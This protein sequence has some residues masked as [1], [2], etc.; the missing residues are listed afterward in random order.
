MSISTVTE[1]GSFFSNV[2]TYPQRKMR[3]ACSSLMR[4]MVFQMGAY[5]ESTLNQF[6]LKKN[7]AGRTIDGD[8]VAS[9]IDIL[10]AIGGRPK[11]MEL[12]DGRSKFDY[13]FFSQHRFKQAVEANGG[14]F[15]TFTRGHSNV[16]IMSTSKWLSE[17]MEEAEITI[18]C[19]NLENDNQ[20]R[21]PVFQETI[22]RKM[23]WDTLQVQWADGEIREAILFDVST[24]TCLPFDLEKEEQKCFL[25]CHAPGLTYSWDR[26]YIGQ[27]LALGDVLV[28]DYPGTQ[29][30]TGIASEGA[31]Y[32]AA[33]SMLR[34]LTDSKGYKSG[35][36][37]ATGFCLG[38]CVA[39]YLKSQHHADE[40][41]YVAEHPPRSVE[42]ICNAQSWP[43]PIVAQI[44]LPG[45]T[46]QE[47]DV[48]QDLFNTLQKLSNLGSYNNSLTII[49]STDTDKLIPAGTYEDLCDAACSASQ[50][51][52]LIHE[53]SPE[54]DGHTTFP[55]EDPSTWQQYKKLILPPRTQEGEKE[56]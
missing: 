5:H 20:H 44:G 46:S 43:C 27:H 29:L 42:D 41:N 11:Q 47:V 48:E 25:R 4:L 13:M 7:C 16:S 15:L 21:W 10:K 40:L 49:I 18:L 33:E 51:H 23:G 31:Y 9:S 50:V 39:A 45:I 30:N 35:N 14:T 36:V 37:F 22:L 17:R 54:E 2:L 32:L 52:H 24:A 8:R 1:S 6:L 28:F 26:N 38:S 19:Q 53:G 3:E 56:D 55:L 34:L 12:L